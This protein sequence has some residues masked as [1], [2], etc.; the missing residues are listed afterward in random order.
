L[1]AGRSNSGRP[2]K[3]QSAVFL[4]KRIKKYFAECDAG[5]KNGEQIQDPL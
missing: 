2:M 3:I 4:N 5:D 1:R